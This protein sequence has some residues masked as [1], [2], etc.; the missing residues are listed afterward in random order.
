MALKVPPLLVLKPPLFN[1]FAISRQG[2]VPLS[3]VLSRSDLTR[4]VARRLFSL[5]LGLSPSI[6]PIGYQSQQSF[7]SNIISLIIDRC[8]LLAGDT[9][10]TD[11]MT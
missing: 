10:N 5:A 2:G 1:S 7:S 8:S 4:A 3:L 9:K 11:P 6:L